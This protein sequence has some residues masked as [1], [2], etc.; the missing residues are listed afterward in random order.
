MPLSSRV[1]KFVSSAA[2]FCLVL[3]YAG[4]HAAMDPSFELD[5]HTLSGALGAVKPMQPKIKR[6]LRGRSASP[7][8]GDVYTAKS[9]DNLFKI[10]MRDYKLSNDEAEAFLEEIK[11]ENNIYDIRRIRVGQKIIIPPV[12]RKADGSLKLLATAG[13]RSGSS[14]PLGQSFKLESPVA[15]LSEQE[16]VAKAHE[17]WDRIVPSKNEQQKPVAIQTSTFSLTLDP[18]RYPAFARM[19]G[20]RII[21]DRNGTIPPLVKTLIEGKDASVRIVSEPPSGT[22][23]LMAS[24]LEAAGFYSVEE[25]FSMEFG[26]DPKLTVQADF[27]V[28]KSAES[29]VKKDVILVNSGRTSLPSSIV[30]FLRKEGFSLHEPFATMKPLAQRDSLTIHT[31]STKKQPEMIDAILSSLSVSA[32]LDRRVDVFAADNNGI[33]LSVK[34]ER[35]FERSGQ[36]YVVTSFDGDPINYTLFRIL[37]AKGYKVVILEAQDDFR[38]ISEKLI[39]QMK[40]KGSFARHNLLQDNVSGFSLQMSGFKIDDATLPGGGIFMTDKTVDR[41]IKELFTENGFNINSR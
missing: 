5:P 3:I 1:R 31:I 37:E 29:L 38:R 7:V 6:A 11:R 10:L 35:F 13:S 32:E 22:R 34:A 15:P 8:N 33:S 17:A 24:M 16:T 19:D 25:N 12:R 14:S 20:G 21:L 41:F 28:E 18:E 39:S 2:F 40:I 23:R 26:S 36:R 27:K 9:G 30:D 4:A